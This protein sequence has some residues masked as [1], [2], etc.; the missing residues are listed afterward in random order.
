[1]QQE[2]YPYLKYIDWCERI[3]RFTEL[4]E[5]RKEIEPLTGIIT[6]TEKELASVADSS[7]LPQSVLTSFHFF[8]F[9]WGRPPKTALQRFLNAYNHS[10]LEILE[11][12]RLHMSHMD[13]YRVLGESEED[14]GFINLQSIWDGQT[15][16]VSLN[17]QAE[18]D[19]NVLSA[20]AVWFVR[21]VEAEEYFF[22]F[23]TPMVF[24]NVDINGLR[25]AIN[26]EIPKQGMPYNLWIKEY[27]P[28]F[29][30]TIIKGTALNTEESCFKLHARKNARNAAFN[31][32]KH[33]EF[34]DNYF[35]SWLDNSLE[36]L[37]NT[38]PR[39][40]LKSEFG[41]K[42]LEKMLADMES[43]EHDSE[44]PALGIPV[45]EIRR[46]LGLLAN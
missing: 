3:A 46:R 42:M 28:E 31:L 20:N 26:A 22:C 2:K 21:L 40:C 17:E 16:P 9:S 13:F 32:E 23:T 15:F 30:Q 36:N 4:D 37:K 12:E 11:L 27:L 29:L 19:E 8:D 5:M 14:L 41:R 10:E 45:N 34:L 25:K 44:V 6:A 1:M 7:M 43:L 38:S 39:Q 18:M 24:Y 35:E 33:T